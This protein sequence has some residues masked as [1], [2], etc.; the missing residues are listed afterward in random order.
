VTIRSVM[1]QEMG[2]AEPTRQGAQAEAGVKASR[3]LG[4]VDKFDPVTS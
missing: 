2:G 1:R 3:Q 4:G